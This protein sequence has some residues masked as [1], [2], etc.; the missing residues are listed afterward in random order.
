MT[1]EEPVTLLVGGLVLLVEP[2]Q[3]AAI[4]EAAA[5]ERSAMG[6]LPCNLETSEDDKEGIGHFAFCA[7]RR[8]L[9]TSAELAAM[10]LS[11]EIKATLEA[12]VCG[13]IACNN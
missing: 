1:N 13:V 7:L 2:P 5:S 3:P 8:L 4:S 11:Q 12:L 6:S 10:P 9:G